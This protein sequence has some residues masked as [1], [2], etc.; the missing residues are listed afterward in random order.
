MKKIAL[1]TGASSGIGKATALQ[2]IKDGYIVYGA[3]RR[4]E[5]MNDIISAGGHA[6]ALDVTDYE[7]VK[8][9]INSII[10]KEGRVDILVNNAGY[11]VYG[12]V[13]EITVEQAKKQFDVNLFG[14]AEVT[15]A[16]IPTMRNQKSGIILNISSVGG[17]IYTPLGAWYHATK[18]ALEGWSDSL[19]LELAQF[20]IDVVIIQPGSIKT[21]FDTAM[22]QQFGETKNSAYGQ[23]KITMKKVMHNAYQPGNYSDPSVI[24]K[25]IS[26]AIKAK[27]PKTRYAAGKMARQTLMGRKWLSDR[28]FDKMMM[29]IVKKFS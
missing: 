6:I 13:E 18:H 15:K 10:Q 29:N 17:K 1:V 11:A 2:L 28:G 23:L 24:A 12:P 27:R 5:K 21:E 9:E 4:V 25:K 26:L 19:R 14:L 8:S 7:Q 22:D 20:G 16:I 3:A